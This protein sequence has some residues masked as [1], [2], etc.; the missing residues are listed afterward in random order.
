[1]VFFRKILRGCQYPGARSTRVDEP[2]APLCMVCGGVTL[3]QQAA[4]DDD[5]ESRL[6]RQYQRS[7]RGYPGHGVLST[8]QLI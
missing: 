4:Q 2:C 8:Q 1:M 5:H 3:A 7:L 6:H